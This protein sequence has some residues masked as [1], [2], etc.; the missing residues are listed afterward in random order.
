MRRAC[1]DLQQ[2]AVS[3]DP[4]VRRELGSTLEVFGRYQQVAG[5]VLYV[6]KEAAH[7]V[8]AAPEQVLRKYREATDLLE[9][10][11]LP[12][13]DRLTGAHRAVLDRARRGQTGAAIE[14]RSLVLVLGTGLV[15][16]LGWLQL[17]LYRRH[18]RLINPAV[19]LATV[20]ALALVVPGARLFWSEEAR[21]RDG[22]ALDS[23][24]D[25]AQARAISR[26]ANA[27]A[28]RFIGDEFRRDQYLQS[29]FA[30]S[31]ILVEVPGAKPDSYAS[32]LATLYQSYGMFLGVLGTTQLPDKEPRAGQTL[33]KVLAYQKSVAA[34]RVMVR[35]EIA[36]GQ[37]RPGHHR[38]QA[39]RG[40]LRLRAVRPAAGG[41]PGR[42]PPRL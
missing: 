3:R 34:M 2:A 1:S 10:E 21:A 32:D 13:A 30:R 12:A 33:P 24:L 31:Q 8:A 16:A 25:L 23:V 27:D 26:D 9:V 4:A 7:P 28:S 39:G 42:R 5:Q 17:L 29:F 40:Q 14:A 38:I 20:A 22:A 18:H 36:A 35:K 19:L 41:L 15:A 37:G 11:A 6:D